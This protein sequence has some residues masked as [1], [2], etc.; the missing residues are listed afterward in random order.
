MLRYRRVADLML[1]YRRDSNISAFGLAV[2]TSNRSFLY[3]RELGFYVCLL[4][5]KVLLGSM[6]SLVLGVL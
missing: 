3:S 4:L 6:A 2:C 1:V 5:K